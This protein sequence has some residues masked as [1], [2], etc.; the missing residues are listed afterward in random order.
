MFGVCGAVCEPACRDPDVLVLA[1]VAQGGEVVVEEAGCESQ[2]LDSVSVV[3]C[4]QD[5][6]EDVV[7]VMDV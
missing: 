6:L 1:Q 7:P 2:V 4:G 3:E 5:L